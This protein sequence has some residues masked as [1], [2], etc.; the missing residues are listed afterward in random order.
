MLI[1][2]VI[3][4]HIVVGSTV[5]I[6]FANNVTNT[7][8]GAEAIAIAISVAITVFRAFDISAAIDADI[9]VALRVATTDSYCG[10]QAVA[11]AI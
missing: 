1:A 11:I 2:V 6:T 9:F 8:F 4:L 7:V 3:T 5:A 10:N